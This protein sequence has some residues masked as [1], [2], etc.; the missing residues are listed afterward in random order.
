MATSL[1]PSP[2]AKFHLKL[3]LMGSFEIS[4][5]HTLA[6]GFTLFICY[7]TITFPF[8]LTDPLLLTNTIIALFAESCL[9]DE[10]VS[11]ACQSVSM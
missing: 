4:G 2:L 9:C 8:S 10:K 11:L 3:F 5:L 6:S 1:S 7:R